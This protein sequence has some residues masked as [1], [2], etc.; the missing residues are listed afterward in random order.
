M[1]DWISPID[2]AELTASNRRN[3]RILYRQELADLRVYRDKKC[4]QLLRKINV[5]F[6]DDYHRKMAAPIKAPPHS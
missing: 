5:I 1:S 3:Q 4:E 2:Q 6:L